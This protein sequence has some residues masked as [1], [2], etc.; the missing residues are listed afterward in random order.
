MVPCAVDG[1]NKVKLRGGWGVE[2]GIKS[3]GKGNGYGTCPVT[4]GV[5]LADAD[6][7]V[8]LL[9]CGVPIADAEILDDL[10]AERSREQ[11]EVL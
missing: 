9:P 11:R 1:G 5:D 8:E 4:A 2:Y 7:V 10:S 3:L 6:V